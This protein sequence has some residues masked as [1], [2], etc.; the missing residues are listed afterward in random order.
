V[1]GYDVVRVVLGLVL[2]TAAALKGYQLAT[3]PIVGW[4]F[5]NSRWFLIGVVDFE[6]FFGLWL[7]ANVVREWLVETPVVIEMRD[8]EVFRAWDGKKLAT[9]ETKGVRDGKP[10]PV[11]GMDRSP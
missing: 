3:E 2:L 4:G 8:G 10:G 1:A 5:L 11:L 9:M 6:L 7:L